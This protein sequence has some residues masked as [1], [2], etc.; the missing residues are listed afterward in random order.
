M[1]RKL[2]LL[3]SVLVCVSLNVFAQQ[4]VTRDDVT[5]LLYNARNAEKSNNKEEAIEIYKQ[6]LSI[7]RS[8][9]VPY[10]KL[11]NIYAEDRD[12]ASSL[13]LS[14]E[15][16]QKYL[17]L[18]PTGENTAVVKNAIANL[19][20]KLKTENVADDGNLLQAFSETITSTAG[21]RTGEG[22]TGNIS[23]KT[24]DDPVRKQS[25]EDN[26]DALW[27]KAQTAIQ[28]NNYELACESLDRIVGSVPPNHPM[29]AQSN[30]LLAN[31][32]GNTA[33]T[34]KMKEAINA[35]ESYMEIHEQVVAE[36]DNTR[37]YYD[38]VVKSNVPFGEELCGVWVSDYAEDKNGLPYVVLEVSKTGTLYSVRILPH[39]TLAKKHS[40]YTGKP[41]GY[42]LLNL[43]GQSRSI[44][45]DLS[46]ETFL[47]YTKNLT[48]TGNDDKAAL[49]FGDGTLQEGS[50]ELAK[51][52]IKAVEK[53]GTTVQK[54]NLIVNKDKPGKKLFM[55]LG[56]IVIVAGASKVFADMAAS[57]ETIVTLDLNINRLFAGCAELIV[58]QN[59]YTRRSDGKKDVSRSAK[60]MKLHKLYPEYNIMFASEGYELFGHKEFTKKE[61]A[62]REEYIYVTATKDRKD[63]NRRSYKKLAEKVSALSQSIFSGQDNGLRH[64][65]QQNFEYAT[66]G[67]SYRKKVNKNGVY[68]GWT[69]ISGKSNGYG[70]SVLNSGYEYLGEWKDDKYYGIGKYS[71]PDTGV[72]IGGFLNDKFHG[73]GIFTF[74]GGGQYDGGFLKGRCHGQGIL[75]YPTGEQYEGQWKNGKREGFGKYITANGDVYEG[76]WKNDEPQN[77]KMVYADGNSYVGQL[78]YDE[79]E[80]RIERHGKGTV[81]HTN[82]EMISGNWKND[83]LIT[84]KK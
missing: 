22:Q 3:T 63:F 2:L 48:I 37:K 82:G 49:Y 67:F 35:L 72:Y 18:H 68:T 5:T 60:T 39:C 70:H 80:N 34:A 44:S 74:N 56:T 11:A 10:L 14:V 24:T 8:F 42:S 30:I 83:E 29:F 7:D 78:K 28:G 38:A 19:K 20:D 64:E 46:K 17:E 62:D 53:M 4:Y 51:G 79:K 15:L 50:P 76:T 31:I 6:L 66:Q 61:L 55:G 84:T 1:K 16:Y 65:I 43:S 25:A 36:F 58:N 32:Y 12:N 69:D 45:G 40:M 77:G 33:N 59:F 73:S 75:T 13:A 52:G 9:P 41:F 71:M 47:A 54:T 23:G 26:V 27:A 57:T 21:N 81:I